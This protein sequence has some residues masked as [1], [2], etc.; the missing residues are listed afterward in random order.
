M[1]RGFPSLSDE[2]KQA[3]LQR[4]K[5]SG[6]RVPVLAKEYGVSPRIIYNMLHHGATGS[7]TVLEL[8]RL[9]REHQALLAIIGQL[10]ANQ[11]MGKKI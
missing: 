6:E 9:K 4:I 8:A 7:S 11:K 1:P 10:V 2:Q 5:E 3:I